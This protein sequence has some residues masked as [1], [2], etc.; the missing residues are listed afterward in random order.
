MHVHT[1]ERADM[2]PGCQGARPS[3]V[4]ASGIMIL[5]MSHHGV[6]GTVMRVVR[7]KTSNQCYLIINPIK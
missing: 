5:T 4:T 7:D 3:A 1:F 2:V 6:T